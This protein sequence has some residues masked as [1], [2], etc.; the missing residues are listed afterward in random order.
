M[1]EFI[2]RLR[3]AFRFFFPKKPCA[4]IGRKSSIDYRANIYNSSNNPQ[5]IIIGE[6]SSI[7][8]ILLVWK[9]KGEIIIG[10]NTYI[11]LGSRVWSA[12]KISI[13]NNVQVAHNVN[14]FDNNIHSIDPKI[15]NKEFLQHYENNDSELKEQEIVIKD[16]VWLGANVIVLKGVTIGENSIVGAGSVIT[17][18]IPVNCI[19]A[20][21]PA[22]V[23]REL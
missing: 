22:R 14:I 21:N 19:V 4:T 11:G 15:R 8:G 7:D 23:I 17:K 13:G 10:K 6:G 20:G 16:N 5:K 18:N 1:K 2:F 9:N 3:L 12:K